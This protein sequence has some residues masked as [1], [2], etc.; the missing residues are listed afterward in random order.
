MRTFFFVS[1][2]VLILLAG[3][4]SLISFWFL[5]LL[6]IVFPYVIVGLYDVL[7]KQNNVTRNYPVVGHI[8]Q[9][10]IS[11]RELLQD[12][13]FENEREVRPFD[14]IQRNIVYQRAN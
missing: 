13:I 8:K 1:A 6:I 12:W 14:L 10:L 7:Q 4:L 11:N 9:L 2:V 3:L 5:L